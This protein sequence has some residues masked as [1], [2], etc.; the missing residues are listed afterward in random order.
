MKPKHFITLSSHY[1]QDGFEDSNQFRLPVQRLAQRTTR[2]YSYKHHLV[3]CLHPR[4][5]RIPPQK[6]LWA[7]YERCPKAEAIGKLSQYPEK[8]EKQQVWRPLELCG[9]FFLHLPYSTL[10][11]VSSRRRSVLIFLRKFDLTRIESFGRI[12][13][14][15]LDA[16]DIP[17]YSANAST[18]WFPFRSPFTI[19][20][21]WMHFPAR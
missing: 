6:N 14:W 13:P 11:S 21:S 17:P 8:A 18:P 16:R 9:V 15:P 20:K 12:L 5:S 4:S 3:P 19:L 2:D 7:T 10:D 1:Q